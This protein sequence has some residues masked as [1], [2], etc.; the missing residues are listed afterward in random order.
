METQKKRFFHR[1]ERLPEGSKHP[2]VIKSV[3][4]TATCR[5]RS[6]NTVSFDYGYGGDAR[7]YVEV[8]VYK[9]HRHTHH[10]HY[11]FDVQALIDGP[12]P[13]EL[14]TLART[15]GVSQKHLIDHLTHHAIRTN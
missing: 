3:D 10:T 14:R 9:P 4:V 13:R 6:P 15:L 7:L 8:M 5:P 12:R 1:D 11:I 2:L